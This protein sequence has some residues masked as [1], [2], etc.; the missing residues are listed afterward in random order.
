MSFFDQHENGG[1]DHS[2]RRQGSQ[3]VED[4]VIEPD[5]IR[6]DGRT[7]Y[8]L[9]TRPP[10]AIVVHCADARFQTAFRRFVTE[11]LGIKSYMPVVIGGGVHALGAQAFLPK[12]FKI[13]WEQIKFAHDLTKPRQII[14]I[15]HEDCRWYEKMGGYHPRISVPQKGKQDLGH[16]ARLLLKDFANVDVRAYWASIVGGNVLFTPVMA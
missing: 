5:V 13:L 7:M 3:D 8:P 15:N 16:A 10:E 12:N 14:I 2:P 4:Q 9:E 11:E 1:G 6:A